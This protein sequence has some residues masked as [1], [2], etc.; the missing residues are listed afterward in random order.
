MLCCKAITVKVHEISVEM[1]NEINRTTV[2]ENKHTATL[3]EFVFLSPANKIQ[4][5]TIYFIV[6]HMIYSKN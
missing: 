6:N 2:A 4:Y 5:T 1:L 3:S